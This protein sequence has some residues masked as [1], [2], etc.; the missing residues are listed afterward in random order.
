MTK[1]RSPEA[2][3]Y[4]LNMLAVLVH[5]KRAGHPKF[6]AGDFPISVDEL[7]T[8]EPLMDQGYAEQILEPRLGMRITPE[9]EKALAQEMERRRKQ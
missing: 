1:P 2:R 6:P 4:Q 9:G 8:W 7:S 5:R 3:Q